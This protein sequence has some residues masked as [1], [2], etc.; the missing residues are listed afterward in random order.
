MDDF[1]V[2]SICPKCGFTLGIFIPG[3]ECPE[4]GELLFP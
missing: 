2:I 4:C 1:G 3:M